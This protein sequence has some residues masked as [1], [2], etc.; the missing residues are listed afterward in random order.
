MFA[1]KRS[2]KKITNFLKRT[3]VGH[4]S[5]HIESYSNILAKRVKEDYSNSPSF[6]EEIKYNSNFLTRLLVTFEISISKLL[7]GGFG[8][9]GGAILASIY[10]CNSTSFGTFF[11]TGLVN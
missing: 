6:E 1:K 5:M 7:P 2:F 11:L 9:Q 3:Y 4:T 8:W 10:G